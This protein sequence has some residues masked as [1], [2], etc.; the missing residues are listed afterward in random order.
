M[1]NN[2]YTSSWNIDGLMT[3]INKD[4]VK[5]KMVQY[6]SSNNQIYTIIMICINHIQIIMIFE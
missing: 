5:I 1:N 6:E 2:N 3:S 4:S